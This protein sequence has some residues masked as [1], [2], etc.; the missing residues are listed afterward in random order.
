ML[1]KSVPWA[2]LSLLQFQIW[3]YGTA[4]LGEPYKF[5]INLDNS[6]ALEEP[7]HTMCFPVNM[8]NV[9]VRRYMQNTTGEP[10]RLG[11]WWQGSV[12]CA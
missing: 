12:G 2:Y 8:M 4:S 7:A 10:S 9:K 5:V 6:T 11:T 1:H 3:K